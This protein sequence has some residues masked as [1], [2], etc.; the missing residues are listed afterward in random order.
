MAG[1]APTSLGVHLDIMLGV[2]MLYGQD[3]AIWYTNVD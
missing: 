2:N 3:A 1:G